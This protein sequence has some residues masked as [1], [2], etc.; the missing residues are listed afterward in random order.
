MPL[1]ICWK[2][3]LNTEIEDFISSIILR[4][5]ALKKHLDNA[6]WYLNKNDTEVY[7]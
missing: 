2:N 7:S 3:S 5:T 4:N 1:I 6:L